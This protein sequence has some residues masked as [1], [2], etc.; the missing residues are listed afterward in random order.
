MIISDIHSSHDTG[1]N[2]RPK[3]N[4]GVSNDCHANNHEGTECGCGEHEHT[5]CGCSEHERLKKIS[6]TVC[7]YAATLL[8]CGATTI[9]TEKNVRR[10]VKAYDAVADFAVLPNEIMLTLWDRS[11]K[12]SYTITNRI[13]ESAIDF[14]R[15]TR[16]SSLSW[17]VADERISIDHFKEEYRTIMEKHRLNPYEV[18]VLTGLANA[19]FCRIFGGD[20]ISMLIVFVG[21][22]CGFYVK[23]M[24]TS[25]LK[26]NLQAA[27]LVSS[28]ISAIICCSGYVFGWGSTP[29]IALGTSVLY[30]IPGIPFITAM[31]DL[32]YGHYV[33][34]LSRFIQASITTISLSLGLCVALIIMQ[35]N[36]V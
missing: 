34:S 26:L 29:D 16:L 12:H 25:R 23:W 8:S 32:I 10:I 33:C 5:E 4:E 19:S 7:E 3:S 22:V 28:C 21:T 14:D 24:M 18:L 31:S 13:H 2:L 27:V 11:K 36:Y 20:W 6:N 9:R 15:I 30:L 17:K 1:S 35:I